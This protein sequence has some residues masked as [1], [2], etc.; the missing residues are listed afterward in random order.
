M[1]TTA[2]LALATLLSPSPG[3]EPASDAWPQW[4]GPGRDGVV[5]DADWPDSLGEE[6]TTL[7]WRV[8]GLGPSYAGPVV[9]GSLVFSVETLDERDEVVRAFDR[10]TGEL[11]WETGWEGSLEVPFFAARNGSWVRAT[12]ALADGVLYVAGMRDVLVALD[13]DTGAVR[14][15][16]DFPAELGTEVP[17]FGFVSSPLVAGDA[18]FVQAGASLCRLDRR[19]GEIEWR[20]LDDAGGMDSAFSS[21]V[22]CRL[23]GRE[24]V[25][26]LTRSHLAGVDPAGGGLLWSRPVEAF[27]GMNILTPQPVGDA[28]LTAPYGGRAQLI[29]VDPARGGADATRE[30][31]RNRAQ[32]YMTSPVVVD[33]HAYLY[34][35]AN[36]L[37]CIE[38]ESGEDA[39]ISPPPGD[40]YWSLVAG[41]GSI[42]AL[43]SSGLLRLVAADPAAYRPLGEVRV[44]DQE[45]WAHLAVAGRTLFVRGQTSLV[46]LRWGE[47]P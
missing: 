28:V 31:W 39:W 12:P 4:R 42:L 15:R 30:L 35:R 25:V 5:R 33:G 10:S 24:Q 16:V 3:D 34:T 40:D 38:L 36:R 43:S 13:A 27:R 11:V 21:P 41:D 44:L 19:T 9:S 45:S 32:G 26:A 46:A 14:W 29:E 22:L 7:L 1:P 23:A 20:A 8:D 2:F 37:H 47:R 6:N 18:L 17:R